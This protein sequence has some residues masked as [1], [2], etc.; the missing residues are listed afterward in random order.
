MQP[1]HLLA[2]REQAR[3]PQVP[4]RTTSAFR[5]PPATAA[6]SLGSHCQGHALVLGPPAFQPHLA[7]ATVPLSE[8][9]SWRKA[10]SVGGTRKRRPN[11]TG[12]SKGGMGTLAWVL[13]LGNHRQRAAKGKAVFR[14]HLP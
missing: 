11:P 1:D 10:S 8:R 5:G 14:A 7:Q 4:F 9:P 3:Q 2:S 13:H 6:R 12:F